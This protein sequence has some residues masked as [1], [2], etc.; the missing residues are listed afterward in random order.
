[1]IDQ[2]KAALVAL[3]ILRVEN[4]LKELEERPIISGGGGGN[5][6]GGAATSISIGNPVSGGGPNQVLYEDSNQKVAGS[7]TFTYNGTTAL[8][9]G[10]TDSN[11][12]G[13]TPDASGNLL[14]TPIG[15][16][17]VLNSN[18]SVG[19][20]TTLPTAKLHLG[21]G[22]ATA[23]TA[24]I[25][26]TAG[27]NTTAIVAGQ[28]EYDGTDIF[29]SITGTRRTVVNTAA[30]QTLTTKTLTTPIIN[31]GSDADGD[32][33]YRNGSVFTRL[34]IGSTGQVIVVSGGFP[35]WSNTPRLS[36]RVVSMTDATS[37]T[38]TGDTADINTQANTQSIGTLTANAPSGTPVNGQL[39]ELVIKS[40]NVQ[41]FSW[42]AIYVG[43]TTTALPTATT[44][45][46]KTDKFFFQYNSTSA[47]W[48]ISNAQYGYA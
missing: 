32:V 4:R 13:M 16:G 46:T 26:L 25:K 23:G 44:G 45:A 7:S 2:I 35:V 34:A 22:T 9:I 41:T 6:G 31:T 37:F 42:N 1:M 39:L 24:P 43:C 27:T 28:V 15:P 29:Y 19:N 21:A 11:A 30:A 36:P 5:G 8:T 33:Y 10:T 12:F 47:K 40:T 17:T 3:K 38:P 48:E 20:G 14:I 18:L